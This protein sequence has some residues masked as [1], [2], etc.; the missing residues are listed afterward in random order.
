MD[1]EMKEMFS[2]FMN[3]IKG[4]KEEMNGIKEEMKVLT[5]KVERNI[6]R[7]IRQLQDTDDILIE[8]LKQREMLPR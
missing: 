8:A 7:D 1:N 6:R 2:Q 3:E 4:I 5:Y